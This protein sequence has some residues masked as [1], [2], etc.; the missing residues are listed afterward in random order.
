M[1]VDVFN[2]RN[3][4]RKHT[5]LI[6]YSSDMKDVT[7]QYECSFGGLDKKSIQSFAVKSVGKKV[8]FSILT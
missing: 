6:L 7:V 8:A 5:S 2:G 1:Y 3:V 4:S